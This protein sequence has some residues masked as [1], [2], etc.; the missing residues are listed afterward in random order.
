MVIM[1]M[2]K[3]SVPV[4][5]F[6]ALF[7]LT[8]VRGE[9]AKSS[10]K[11]KISGVV[12][13]EDG[14]PAANAS[15]RLM[16]PMAKKSEGSAEKPAAQ[17]ADDEKKPGDAK[18]SEEK[19]ARPKPVAE[20]KTDSEGKFTLEAPAGKYRLMA[21]LRG[22]GSASQN[23]ELTAGKNVENVELKLKPNAKKAPV[24]EKPAKPTE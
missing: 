18:P 8:A 24:A 12:L 17:A 23:V 1:K 15:V 6:A 21:N 22:T 10:E 9:D 3:W 7:A 2:M 13:L 14:K 4:F 20:T 11:V 5:A 16:P 19:P